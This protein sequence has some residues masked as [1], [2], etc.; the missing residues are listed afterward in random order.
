VLIYVIQK[1]NNKILEIMNME[2]TS[3]T[4]GEKIPFSGRNY[5]L[6]FMP[7]VDCCVLET[8]FLDPT[9]R[10]SNYWFGLLTQYVNKSTRKQEL[11]QNFKKMVQCHYS[12]IRKEELCKNSHIQ[13]DVYCK[14]EIPLQIGFNLYKSWKAYESGLL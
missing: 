7:K 14:T 1:N 5:Y 10:E 11:S 12:K 9:G 2:K 8:Y 4:R 3:F 13:S 6:K